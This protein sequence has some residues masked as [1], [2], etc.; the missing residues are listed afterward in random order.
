M[1]GMSNLQELVKNGFRMERDF[2]S[3]TLNDKEISAEEFDELWDRL[4]GFLYDKCERVGEVD[5][6]VQDLW[7]V[8]VGMYKCDNLSL[9]HI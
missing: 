3:Y 1:N 6:G 7:W 4:L 9:I 5:Y 2:K 8:R